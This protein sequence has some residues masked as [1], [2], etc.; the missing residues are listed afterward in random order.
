MLILIPPAVANSFYSFDSKKQETRFL[1]LLSE[2]R[3]LVCQNQDLADS[4]ATLAQD[5][6]HQVYTLMQ[7]G[8]SD[9]EIK[10]YLSDRF[11][12]FILFKPPLK[13]TTLALWFG[14]GVFLLMGLFLFRRLFR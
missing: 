3:C 10:D 5:L 4:N 7:Q 8:R 9:S 13:S 6:R 1:S 14:P 2:L 11:G 12:D